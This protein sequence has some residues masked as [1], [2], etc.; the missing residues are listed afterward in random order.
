MDFKKKIH[1]FSEQEYQEYYAGL[2]SI[3]R[4]RNTD[5][6][7]QSLK[8]I[9]SSIDE[10]TQNVVD[11]GC[12]GGYLL[13]YL[14]NHYPQVKFCGCDIIPKPGGFRFDYIQSNIEKLPIKDAHF[15]FVT[16]CHTLE[17][18]VELRQAV[19]ELLRVCRKKL[20]IVVPCQRYY[21]FTLDEHI[22]FFTHKHQLVNLMG[23][24][25]HCIE[26]CEKLQGDW[27]LVVNCETL[28]RNG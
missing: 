20:I 17:H 10:H 23:I 14:F 16:C 24:E 18:I 7:R 11:I 6:N 1:D 19:K 15:D 12:G 9:A 2:N 4:N 22:N 27:V 13:K 21:Y 26:K 28:T 25:P 5:L 8:Y 3:S